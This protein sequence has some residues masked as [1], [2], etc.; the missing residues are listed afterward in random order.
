MADSNDTVN[1]HLYVIED[2]ELGTIDEVH[3]WAGRNASVI[4]SFRLSRFKTDNYPVYIVCTYDTI[5]KDC[6]P[7]LGPI[8]PV[9]KSELWKYE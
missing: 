6:V 5:Q 7:L 9:F 1:W 3:F 4:H 2:T 8:P